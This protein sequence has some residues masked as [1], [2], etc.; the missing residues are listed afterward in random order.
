MTAN[1]LAA[2]I[3]GLLVGLGWA[4]ML[5]EHGFIKT[6]RLEHCGK[7]YEWRKLKPK[8][9]RGDTPVRRETRET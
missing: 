4:W 3:V 5:A 6:E 7:L 2:F 9:R 8:F 1:E